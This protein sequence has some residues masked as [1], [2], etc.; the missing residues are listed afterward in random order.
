MVES[1]TRRGGY[2]RGV[3]VV[4]SLSSDATLS[5]PG[6]EQPLRARVPRHRPAACPARPGV[7]WTDVVRPVPS[8]FPSPSCGHTPARGRPSLVPELELLVAADVVAL[9][10]AMEYERGGPAEDPPFW[11]AAW[12][13]GQVL[14][15][16]VLDAPAV[17]A[18]PA[19]LDLGS[20]SGLV[21]VA[22]ARAGAAEVVASEVDPFG[23]TAIGAERAAQRRVRDPGGRATCWP[24]S[25]RATPSSSPATSA[26]TG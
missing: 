16:Y 26:T 19:V 21:A 20:G 9:W 3:G 12:P 5:L 25:R 7:R 1:H 10:E 15:R 6:R 4:N 14:A 24:V 18:R 22:A 23:R 13:G 11:A 2:R 8:P 17:V